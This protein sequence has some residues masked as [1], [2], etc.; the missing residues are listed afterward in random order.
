MKY[1]PGVDPDFPYL[2]ENDYFQFPN[3]DKVDGGIVAAGGNLSPGMLISAYKQGIFPWYNDGDPLLWQSPDPRFI[4][5]PENL[6]ISSSMKKVF[7]QNEYK[8]TFDTVF[9]TVIKSCSEIKRGG[10]NGTWITADMQKAYTK[11]WRLGIAHSCEAWYDNELAG[12]CYGLRI[13]R[14]FFGESMFA[15]RANASKAAFLTYAQKLFNED[16]IAFID[17]Q[18]VS[19]HLSSLGGEELS[20]GDFL[21][22][23]RQTLKTKS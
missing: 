10:Q 16:G 20:R 13:G 3:P 11:L 6:H 18:T 5:R 22:L 21:T 12:G 17:C 7:R 2:T 1:K 8:I 23:L 14:V 19:V 4:I 15:K 9:P